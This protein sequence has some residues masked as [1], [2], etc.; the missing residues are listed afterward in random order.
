MPK[1]KVT[2]RGNIISMRVS[3][4][5]RQLLKKIASRHKLSISDMMRQAMKCFTNNSY[6]SS[7]GHTV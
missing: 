7:M 5:E 6:D 4:K 2:P 1:A 3:E